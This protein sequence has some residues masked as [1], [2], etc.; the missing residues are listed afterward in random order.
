[1]TTRGMG[2]DEM[3]TIAHLI[4]RTA[5]DFPGAKEEVREAVTALCRAFP[6]FNK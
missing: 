2:E 6:L 5:T 3:R 1:M 4:T